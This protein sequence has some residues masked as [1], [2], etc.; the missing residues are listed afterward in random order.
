MRE[1]EV[2]HLYWTDFDAKEGTLSVSKKLGFAPK[3]YEERTVPI[4][5]ELVKRLRARKVRQGGK[6]RLI[7]PTSAH[8]KGRGA[9]GGQADGHLLRKLKGLAFRASLNCGRCEATLNKKPVSCATHPV[10]QEFGLH[11]FRH[12]Y[13]TNLLRDGVDLVSLQKLLG[14]KD[15]DST[16]EYLLALEAGDLRKKILTTGLAKRFV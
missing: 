4:F 3:N 16:R 12:T 6:E 2:S 7:F 5:N 15:L 13:A 8:N 11:K 14:H 9:P 1:A 10:C